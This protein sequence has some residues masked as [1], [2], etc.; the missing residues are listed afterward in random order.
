MRHRSRRFRG[1]GLRRNHCRHRGPVGHRT[2]PHRAF[3]DACRPGFA[4]VQARPRNIRTNAATRGGPGR[5]RDELFDGERMASP[6]PSTEGAAFDRTSGRLLPIRRCWSIC[7]HP[8]AC[9]PL[10]P[11]TTWAGLAGVT[12]SSRICP[13]A[14]GCPRGRLNHWQG[15]GFIRAGVRLR[16]GISRNRTIVSCSH[17]DPAVRAGTGM[18]SCGLPCWTVTAPAM[19]VVR[20]WLRHDQR[21]LPG[22]AVRPAEL[23]PQFG[24]HSHGG[25]LP[26]AGH[27]H[28][29][30][31]LQ[32]P[33]RPHAATAG[34]AGSRAAHFAD[35]RISFGP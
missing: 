2:P 23:A 35:Q 9:P 20:G 8:G 6:S 34:G 10:W 14:P 18:A 25:P 7:V 32:H 1:P 15:L 16:D 13:P 17:G 12:A 19:F 4:R 26:G 22:P 27:L 21:P 33:R 29:H 28:E 5:C 11:A 24:V 31:R 3:R 30:R